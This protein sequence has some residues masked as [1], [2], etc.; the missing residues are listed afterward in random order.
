VPS[1]LPKYQMYAR[2]VFGIGVKQYFFINGYVF[3]LNSPLELGYPK[4]YTNGDPR[5]ESFTTEARRVCRNL[6]LR[7]PR[8]TIHEA[9]VNCVML[10]WPLWNGEL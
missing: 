9:F 2:V 6:M 7:E 10:V 5:R 4:N 8:A 3:L 1:T